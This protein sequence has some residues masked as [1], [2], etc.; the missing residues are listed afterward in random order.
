MS[1]PVAISGAAV[2]TDAG[3]DAGPG[4]GPARPGAPAA[5]RPSRVALVIP[6]LTLGGAERV[7]CALAE[8]WARAGREVSVVTVASRQDDVYALAPGVRRVTLDLARPSRHALDALLQM[9][10]RVA[11]LRRALRALE[12][13]V[14]VCFLES[15]N[16]LSLLAASG[17]GVPVFVCVRTDPRY[18]LLERR[19]AVLRRWLYPRAR[20]VVVQTEGAAAWARRFCP[21]VHVIPN[22][23]PRPARVAAPGA[24]QGAKRLLAMGRLAAEKGFD[25]LIEA[26]AQ[27]AGAHPDW[28]LSILGEGP[29][30]PGLETLVARLGLGERVSLPGFAADPFAELAAAHAFA[31]PSRY[32]GFPNALLEA[33]ACGLPAVA[34]DCPSGPAEVIVHGQNGLLVPPGDGRR[35]AAAL[36]RVMGSGAERARMGR[37]AREVTVS[38]APERV[39]ARWSALLREVGA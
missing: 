30:R 31:L 17:T 29:A 25:V 12:P 15:A 19:W 6:A 24:E 26:F 14:V 27:V 1:P 11:A 18:A 3:P 2:R 38:L 20:G 22:F 37:S 33:M 35:L 21:R 4:A 28:S 39:L 9:G 36:D 13:A 7:V 16:V 10:R 34:F 23:A 8:D 32:E 5:G